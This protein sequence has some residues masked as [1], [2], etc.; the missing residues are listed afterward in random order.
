MAH[1]SRQT[2]YG[3]G[4]FYALSIEPKTH[5]TFVV[6][7]DGKTLREHSRM[8]VGEVDDAA[9]RVVDDR[10]LVASHDRLVE[11]DLDLGHVKTTLGSISGPF[12]WSPSRIL[13]SSG[14]YTGPALGTTTCTP[15]WMEQRAV[16]ACRGRT[17][18]TMVRPH[19][20]LLPQLEWRR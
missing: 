11:L 7:L 5:G 13:E 15:L 9:L 20:R 10:V 16:Y 3:R 8:L 6:R 18:F 19:P 2:G 4:A 12:A 14:S 1:D 17:D